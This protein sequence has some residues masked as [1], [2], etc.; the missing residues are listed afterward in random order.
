MGLFEEI[1]SRKNVYNYNP[2]P[3]TQEEKDTFMKRMYEMGKS[4]RNVS[5]LVMNGTVLREVSELMASDHEAEVIEK[6]LEVLST[7]YI[8]DTINA[9]R[10]AE[11]ERLLLSDDSE[12]KV[13]GGKIIK[14]LYAKEIVL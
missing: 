14:S 6:L 1:E 4:G 12:S 11:L 5:R 9:K 13:L 7:L 2:G 10:Y 8:E 3:L